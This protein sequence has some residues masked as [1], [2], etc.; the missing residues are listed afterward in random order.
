MLQ[1]LFIQILY[2]Y[3][4]YIVYL[5]IQEKAIQEAIAITK[6]EAINELTTVQTTL[7]TSKAQIQS[8]L[9]AARVKI[10]Q[11]EEEMSVAVENAR[12]K[13]FVEYYK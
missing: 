4:I 6:T 12:Q 8:E 11:L 5:V 13:G 7:E 10:A 1:I 9:L 3:I 2:I